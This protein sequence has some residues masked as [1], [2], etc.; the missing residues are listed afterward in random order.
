[1]AMSLEDTAMSAEAHRAQAIAYFNAAWDLIDTADRSAEQD[2]EM[3]TRASA[4]RQHWI[5]AGG[6]E[7]NLAV[8]DWQVAHAASQ[9]GMADIALVFARAAVERAESSDLPTWLKA[10]TH[11][12]LARAHALAG[13]TASYTYEADLTRALLEKVSDIANRELIES[14]LASIP[15]PGQP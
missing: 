14:Q 9:A 5:D 10:S 11:E 13:D 3:L 2:R 1:M 4:S 8:A 7:E 6:T 12:G 15:A